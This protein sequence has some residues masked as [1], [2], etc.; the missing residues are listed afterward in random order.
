MRA[1]SPTLNNIRK[2]VAV[3]DIILLFSIIMI[4]VL[5]VSDRPCT[6]V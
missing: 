1:R 4:G 3:K 2:E 6:V 5:S